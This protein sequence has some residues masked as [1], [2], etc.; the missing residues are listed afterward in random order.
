VIAVLDGITTG[1][2][3]KQIASVRAQAMADIIAAGF[4]MNARLLV[5]TIGSGPGDADLAV[6]TQLE[7]SG[8]NDLF[9][10][11]SVTCKQSSVT[12]AFARLAQTSSP[13]PMDVLSALGM[14]QSQ[15]TGLTNTGPIYV[16]VMSNLLNAVAPLDLANSSV[17]DSDPAGLVAAI[18]QSGLMPDCAGWNVYAV[19]AGMSTTKSISDIANAQLESFWSDF[20]ARCGGKLVMYTGELAQFPVTPSPGKRITSPDYPGLFASE[21]GDTVTVTMPD[22]VLFTSG[23]AG[24]EPQAAP[25][26]AELL[27]FLTTQYPTGTIEVAG[28]TDDVPINIPGGNFTLSDERAKAVATWLEARGI[29]GSRII[30]GGF[31]AA[32]LVASNST[33]TGR[34]LNRRVEVQVTASSAS[35]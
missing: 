32:S 31:G 7:A 34:E 10:Q 2:A 35:S 23:S 22:S 13:G 12:A 16:V 19:S 8:P 29:P 20:F 6:N 18:Q 1:D 33:A 3:D 11:E 24:L 9:R 26:L 4:D 21:A 30:T 14:L 28:Y 27:G 5:D 15:L 25:V 17:L